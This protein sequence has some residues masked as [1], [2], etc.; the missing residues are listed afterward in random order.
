MTDSD[1]DKR[2]E[3]GVA[4]RAGC[5]WGNE[6]LRERGVVS[7]A[8]RCT[9]PMCGCVTVPGQIKAALE[10]AHKTA[11]ARWRAEWEQTREPE[12]PQADPSPET[13]N[14]LTLGG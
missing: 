14:V 10:A 13:S 5:N 7:K 12:L 11:M 2:I 4:I 1:T 6:S 8:A 9:Y 3:E